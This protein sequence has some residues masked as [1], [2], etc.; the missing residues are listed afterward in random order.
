ME[1][2]LLGDLSGQEMAEFEANLK[3]YP[4]LRQ[5]LALAES[6]LRE[7]TVRGAMH[8]PPSV[9]SR[10]DAAVGG[11]GRTQNAGRSIL[12]WQYATAACIVLALASGIVA[13]NFWS[14][15]KT[16]ELSLKEL[17]ALNEQ[18]A[19]NYD[20][21][22]QRLDRI[23]DEMKVYDNPAFQRVVMRNTGN[24]TGALA[25]VYWNTNT[26]ETYLRVQNLRELTREQQYQLWAIVDG[27][28][29]DMGVFD[30]SSDAGLVRM[31]NISN[32]GAFAITIEPRGGKPQPT[33]ETM[34]VIGMVAKS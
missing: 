11:S 32:A 7:F 19:G 2:Y 22:N 8:P 16:T 25:S 23:E 30:Y 12:F 14:N 28:P 1:A 34:Q 27:K 26:A 9:K 13:F 4:Q 18:V 29:M 31:K 21:V 5:E 24:A 17:R 20:R 6:T 3:Q 33:M 15:W 10:I